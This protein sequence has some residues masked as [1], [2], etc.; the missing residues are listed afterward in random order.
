MSDHPL[1][2]VLRVARAVPDRADICEISQ[3]EA[4]G[5]G[6]QARLLA[7]ISGVRR[8]ATKSNRTMAVASLEDLSGRIDLVLFPDVFERYRELLENGAIL[9]VRGRMDRRGETLQIICESVSRDL[10]T[11]PMA[12]ETPNPVLVRFSVAADPW[13]EIRAMQR[14]D[15]ILQRHEGANPVI[16]E[17]PAG[18]GMAWHLR[19]RSR[20][21]EWS[22][23]LEGELRAVPGVMAAALTL[24]RDT[25]LAS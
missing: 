14:V 23:A 3:L 24:P 7:M 18:D 16:L 9:D 19:S 20:R 13:V 1:T 25:R 5:A 12:I 10:P 17:I 4:K 15:E 22:Q 6:V 11:P 8:V 21:V 2:E